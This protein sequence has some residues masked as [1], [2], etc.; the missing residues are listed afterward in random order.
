VSP[1]FRRVAPFI[2]LTLLYWPVA[3]FIL[4][5]GLMGD[6]FPD[7]AACEASREPNFWRALAGE[8]A[9]YAMMFWILIKRGTRL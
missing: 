2:L 3:L 5:V 9:L 1:S 7:D 6:C 4:G 8:T